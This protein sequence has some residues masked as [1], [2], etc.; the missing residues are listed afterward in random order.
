MGNR[1][2]R[3]YRVLEKVLIIDNILIS[4]KF[5]LSSLY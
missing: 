2:R 3:G 1:G 4:K 5:L